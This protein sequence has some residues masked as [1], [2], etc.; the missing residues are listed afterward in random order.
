MNIKECNN[1]IL[2]L[3]DVT[4]P[5]AYCKNGTYFNIFRTM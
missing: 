2:K 5:L 3:K 1:I 4:F